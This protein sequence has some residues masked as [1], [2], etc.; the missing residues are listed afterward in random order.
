MTRCVA[1]FTELQGRER[2]TVSCMF[3]RTR[4]FLYVVIM[5]LVMRM[6]VRTGF[7]VLL[8]CLHG[9]RPMTGLGPVGAPGLAGKHQAHQGLS[10]VLCS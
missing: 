5:V 6:Q 10:L 1:M 9:V 4:V 2:G 8:L 7:K 3:E